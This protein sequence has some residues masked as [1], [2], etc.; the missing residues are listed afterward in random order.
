M[1]QV[2][3]LPATLATACLVYSSVVQ[4]EGHPSVNCYTSRKYEQLNTTDCLRALETIV[5]DEN[6]NLDTISNPFTV[7]Y[8]DCMIKIEKPKRQKPK[9]DHVLDIVAD[10]IKSCPSRG[11]LSGYSHGMSAQVFPS[12]AGDLS[13]L[14]IP[15]CS[16]RR[17]QYEARDCS[18]ALDLVGPDA[19]RVYLSPSSFTSGNCTITLATNDDSP[20]AVS[21]SFLRPTYDKL[22]KRCD[23]DP[24]WVYIS[25][26]NTGRIDGMRLSTQGSQCP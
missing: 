14:N 24:G 12:S 19:D 26:G 25:A 18:S 22:V 11:G 15:V 4:G 6:L 23:S 16:A 9:R 13:D 10:V 21:S 3:L 5:W 17:C 7:G 1:K 8:A 20:F 2:H